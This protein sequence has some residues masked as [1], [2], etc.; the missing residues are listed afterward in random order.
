MFFTPI[1]GHSLPSPSRTPAVGGAPK[2]GSSTS[3]VAARNLPRETSSSGDNASDD[4]AATGAGDGTAAAAAAATRSG[5]KGGGPRQARKAATGVAGRRAGGGGK[6]AVVVDGS[7][8]Y[9]ETLAY[10]SS[11]PEDALK[12]VGPRKAEQLAKL[13]NVGGGSRGVTV[14]FGGGGDVDYPVLSVIRPLRLPVLV[15]RT[16]WSLLLLRFPLCCPGA[17]LSLF[18]LRQLSPTRYALFALPA[19]ARPTRS[20]KQV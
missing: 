14:M 11:P 5:K 8:A 20:S 6:G 15:P 1:R 12:G 13:G 17:H 10:L 19:S 4:F 3:T 18:P 16:V 2:R 7:Y 9:A